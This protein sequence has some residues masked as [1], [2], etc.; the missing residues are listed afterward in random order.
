MELI[1]YNKNDDGEI[2]VILKAPLWWWDEIRGFDTIS[3]PIPGFFC[4]MQRFSVKGLDIE[5]FTWCGDFSRCTLDDTLKYLRICLYKWE[6]A[7][8]DEEKIRVEKQFREILP[9]SLLD[10]REIRFDSQYELMNH[11]AAPD[12]EEWDNEWKQY[13]DLLWSILKSV[14]VDE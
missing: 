9:L 8:K 1:T 7:N 6:K 4:D 3:H 11:L 10:S 14:W 2:S 13:H 5:D 12:M